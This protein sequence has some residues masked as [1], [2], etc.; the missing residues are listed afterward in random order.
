MSAL[1]RFLKE[2]KTVKKNR[3]Y[4]PTDWKSVV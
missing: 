3:K 4:A 1:S 2:N